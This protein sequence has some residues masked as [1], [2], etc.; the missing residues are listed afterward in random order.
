V[1][2]RLIAFGAGLAVL[3]GLV[4][5]CGASISGNSD[6]LAPALGVASTVAP[7]SP[8]P[9]SRAGS[10]ASP[11]AAA[12]QPQAASPPAPK[13][14]N[15]C[16]ANT[17]AQLV[18]VN[19]TAQHVWMCAGTRTVYDTAVTTGA[20][21][22]P[23]DS[24]PTGN[25]TI[26]GRDRNTVLT[27]NTGQQYDVKYWIPFSAPLFGFHDAGWQTFPFGSAKYK[28][29][30]SHGCVHMPLAAMKFL[31]KWAEIGATVHIRA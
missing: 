25:F 22:L 23:Y 8:A 26:Q 3:A 2:S 28:T 10:A 4:A 19:I 15:H 30:G 31:Y 14:A 16:A 24:T 18:L 5:G 21:S 27:L 11:A 12:A 7:S 20:V 29:Q 6:P 17:H 1:G 9:V 13:L